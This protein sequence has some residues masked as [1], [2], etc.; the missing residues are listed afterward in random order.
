MVRNLVILGGN[1]HPEL[2]NNI[3][4]FLGIPQCDRTL[5]KFEV[6]E[7]RCEIKETVRGKDVYIIQTA[8][9]QDPAD[10]VN[11]HFIETCI[12]QT[13]FPLPPTLAALLT[14][15]HSGLCLQDWLCQEGHCRAATLP[16]FATT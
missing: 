7:S 9:T 2:V 14:T 16:L 6:G 3:C 11:D 12:S 4:N 13:H 8:G 10:K 1:S 5:T 15:S